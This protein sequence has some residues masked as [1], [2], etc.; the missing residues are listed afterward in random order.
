MKIRHVLYIAALAVACSRA[1][2]ATYTLSPTNWDFEVH[3]LATTPGLSGTI[4]NSF[5][6]E[7]TGYS[8]FGSTSVA[9]VLGT[10]VAGTSASMGFDGVPTASGFSISSHLH[11]DGG[12]SSFTAQSAAQLGTKDGSFSYSPSG[13]TISVAHDSEPAGTPFRIT[14]SGSISGSAQALQGSGPGLLPSSSASAGWYLTING[15][16]LLSGYDGIN[17]GFG[18][19]GGGTLPLSDSNSYS[20]IVPDGGSF[21]LGAG[22]DLAANASA[23]SPGAS[24][25]LDGAIS[26]SIAPVPAP[27]SAWLLISGL[28]GLLVVA[29]R[30]TNRS[31]GN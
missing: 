3:G 10:T 9:N 6:D 22:Y 17:A 4:S 13:W 11:V 27:A 15:A 25:T 19:L 20:F 26:V 21:V 7:E 29:R 16:A 5:F 14:V 8:A 23:G 28:G 1:E 2:A 30:R 24:A 12:N 31:A 18:S